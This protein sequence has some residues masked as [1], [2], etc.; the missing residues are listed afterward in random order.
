MQ[1]AEP[2]VYFAELDMERLHWLRD[3]NY[4]EEFLSA[5][6]DPHSKPLGC[7]PGQIWERFPERYR[8]LCEPSPF[9]F[10]YRYLDENLDAWEKDYQRIYRG[11]YERIRK[12]YGKLQFARTVERAHELVEAYEREK[13]QKV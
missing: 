1:A 9:S 4:D 8:E 3:R 12:I 11:D 5:P 10:N 6:V 2:G 13:G 7:R